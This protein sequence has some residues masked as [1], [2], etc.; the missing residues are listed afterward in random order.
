MNTTP[1]IKIKKGKENYRPMIIVIKIV[2]K[3]L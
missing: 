1:E 2:N 3:A